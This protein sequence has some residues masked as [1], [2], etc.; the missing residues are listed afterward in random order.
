[1]RYRRH[2]LKWCGSV[3]ARNAIRGI[4]CVLECV[5]PELWRQAAI[6]QHTSSQFFEFL[7]GAFDESV[8]TG[9]IC[10]RCALLDGVVE[11][12]FSELATDENSVLVCEQA[13]RFADMSNKIF[14]CVA[15]ASSTSAL[16]RGRGGCKISK[17]A[18]TFVCPWSIGPKG[19]GKHLGLSCL[20]WV[21]HWHLVRV[22]FHLRASSSGMP[23]KK[24]QA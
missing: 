20:L 16:F 23:P 12:V 4:A 8:E 7:V 2:E 19:I 3:Y 14:E 15:G 9:T 18:G 10:W 17:T 1:M 11:A 6:K 5:S 24:R 13:F 21:P 22:C